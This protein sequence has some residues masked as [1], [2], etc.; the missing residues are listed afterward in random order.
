MESPVNAI[1][2]KGI[3]EQIYLFVGYFFAFVC[4]FVCSPICNGIKSP[5]NAKVEKGICEQICESRNVLNCHVSP[6]ARVLGDS[7]IRGSSLE[8]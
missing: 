7:I 8:L 4:L 3:C 2:E 1:D 6:L 5:V